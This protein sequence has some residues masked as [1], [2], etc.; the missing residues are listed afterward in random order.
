MVQTDIF[1]NYFRVRLDVFEGPLDLL[2]YLI[3]KNELDIHEVSLADVTEEYM[4]YVSVIKVLDLEMAGEYLL[5]AATL[6]KIKSSSLFPK[7]QLEP[8]EEI[9]REELIQH[10][11][12]YQKIK[13]MAEL[14]REREEEQRKNYVRNVK[15]DSEL[16]RQDPQINL[17]DIQMYDLLSALRD[18]LKNVKEGSPVHSI[19]L[20]RYSVERR[21]EEILAVFKTKT[22]IRFNTLISGKTKAFVI[23]SFIAILELIRRGD[24]SFSQSRA[25]GPIWITH[26]KKEE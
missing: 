20:S 7:K 23:V 1:E 2:L 15:L 6:L 19:E 14:L 9:L 16:F 24:V 3:R 21:I 22:R 26:K 4:E 12:K 18:V 5:I 17:G 11:L 8:E 25:F 10:L 13:E